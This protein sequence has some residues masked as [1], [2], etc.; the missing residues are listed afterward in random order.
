MPERRAAAGA[1]AVDGKL[2]V[3]G[4]VDGD[5]LARTML[6]YEPSSAAWSTAAGPPTA[7]EHLGVAGARTRLFVVGGRTG[8]IG[9]NLDAAEAYS[10]RDRS[11]TKLPRM[12]TA[13]GGTAAAASSNG[14]VVAAGGEATTTF[15]EVEAFDLRAGRWVSLPPMP[16]ARHGLGVAAIGTT[17]FVIAGGPEP[18]FAFSDANE[19]FDLA[20][21][22]G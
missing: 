15:D 18:G 3:A 2:Y 9:S 4:G 20:S 7:R 8:G 17:V 10:P 1:A 13:R 5:G 16:T 19:A 11:W 22:R 12:P 6:V 14:F 21:L